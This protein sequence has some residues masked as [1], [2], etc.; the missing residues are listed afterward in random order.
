MPD[1]L[2]LRLSALGDGDPLPLPPAAAVRARGDQRRA[3]SRAAVGGA[4]A[5]VVVLA[6]GAVA[7][8]SG[9]TDRLQPAPPA[10]PSPTAS[11][12]AAAA[13]RL[14]EALLVAG[15]LPAPPTWTDA[16]EGLTLRAGD[17]PPCDAPPPAVGTAARAWTSD[18]GDRASEE[19]RDYGDD[20]GA[21]SA[22]STLGDAVRGCAAGE[23]P[24]GATYELVSGDGAFVYATSYAARPAVRE[25]VAFRLLNQYLLVVTWAAEPAQE[26]DL[27]SLLQAADAKAARMLYGRR[28]TSPAP[29]PTASPTPTRDAV[30]TAALPTL[31]AV[32]GVEEAWRSRSVDAQQPLA[33]YAL[34][35]GQVVDAPQRTGLLVASYD[36]GSGVPSLTAAVS[37]YADPTTARKAVTR[38]REEVR[39]C[40]RAKTDSDDGT[41]YTDYDLVADP[42]TDGADL[43]F[44]VDQRDRSTSKAFVRRVVL[45]VVGRHVVE[46]SY[47]GRDLRMAAVYADVAR[48]AAGAALRDPDYPEQA[49]ARHGGSAW[50]VY[51]WV[52]E[53]AQ[54]DAAAAKERERMRDLGYGGGGDL[55]C[56]RGA[57]EAVREQAEGFEV[58]DDA[59]YTAVAAYFETEAQARRF[60]EVDREH[61]GPE[62]VAVARVT[63]Y[64][65]D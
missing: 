1:D 30:P 38:L 56:D 14:P 39:A 64:C 20:A 44:D 59:K 8:G 34:C 35:D 55:D 47:H 57:R 29:S 9:S 22:F 51:T 41:G 40:P 3:R 17:P 46:V 27:R 32:R 5:A 19:L 61:G 28:T 37:A 50:A 58:R 13:S 52:V 48:G 16:S 11:A 21:L 33:T 24:D 65:L 31:E 6:G 4:A 15:E 36:S 54:D 60:V 43:A 45:H 7:L 2:D 42:A 49:E 12:T 23:R 10:A 63:T 25:L 26:A 62:P 18:R 53:G